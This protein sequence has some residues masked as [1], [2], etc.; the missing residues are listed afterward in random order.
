VLTW[1]YPLDI[2]FRSSNVHGWP[3]VVI[4][5]YGL[6]VWGG[7]VI[8]GYGCT[9]VP[10]IPGRYT[11]YIQLYTPISSSICQ[12]ITAWITNNPPE[13][14]DSKFIA[15]GKG[16]E[17]PPNERERSSNSGR[18]NSN[19]GSFRR[20]LFSVPSQSLAFAATVA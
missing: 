14:F 12:R 8:R 20:I 16:R 4:G 9:H 11:R 3:Q 6:T 13:F 1:N 18:L 19:S 10:T 7:D 17:G 15:Q 5:V 2:M